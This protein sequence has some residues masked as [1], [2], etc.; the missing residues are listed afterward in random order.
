MH[1][2]LRRQDQFVV[3]DHG[4]SRRG[5]LLRDGS[6]E[7]SGEGKFMREKYP[8]ALLQRPLVVDHYKIND[9]GD[10]SVRLPP[11]LP[12]NQRGEASKD[13]RFTSSFS[14]LDHDQKVKEVE[15]FAQEV[16]WFI[17]KVSKEAVFASDI[18]PLHDAMNRIFIVLQDDP[19]Y[20]FDRL[21]SSDRKLLFD[22][23]VESFMIQQQ[24]YVEHAYMHST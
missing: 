20:Q 4:T 3:R 16:K 23:C 2:K 14:T 7:P 1:P 19:Q 9:I 18:Y 11:R 15:R 22:C 13:P 5:R 10:D 12:I 21:S 6:K 24:K 8:S 17:G